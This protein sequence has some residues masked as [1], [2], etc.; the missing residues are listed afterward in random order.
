MGQK[1]IYFISIKKR[2]TLTFRG[3][4]IGDKRE[5]IICR[6]G[7]GVKT[8]INNSL[9]YETSIGSNDLKANSKLSGSL[10]IK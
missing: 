5:D 6:Y 9:F 1:N 3:I 8:K 4:S 7:K 2:G 10:V